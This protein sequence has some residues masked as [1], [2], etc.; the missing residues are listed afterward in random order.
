MDIHK[1]PLKFTRR[2]KRPGIPTVPKK[3]SRVRRLTLPGLKTHCKAVVGRRCGA[4]ERLVTW[5][6]EQTEGPHRDLSKHGPLIS[7]KSKSHLV[8]E[9]RSSP[10]MVWSNWTSTCKNLNLHADG[11]LST[12][13]N[14]KWIKVKCETQK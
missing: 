14:S 13:I 10:Q 6:K 8:E 4:G 7:A 12:K 5:V 3:N 2:C 1:L 11:T 9:G